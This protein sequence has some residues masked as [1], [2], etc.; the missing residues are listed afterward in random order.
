M[1]RSNV[2]KTEEWKGAFFLHSYVYFR[3]WK[4]M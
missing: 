2:Q 4:Y 3:N 1:T